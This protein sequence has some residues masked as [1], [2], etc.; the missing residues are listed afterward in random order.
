MK[1][2]RWPTQARSW[3]EWGS[4]V[5]RFG[6][7]EMNMLRYDYVPVNVSLKLRRTRSKSDSKSRRLASV[8]NNRSLP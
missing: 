6:E 4:S 5:L 8:V 1:D 2:D 7:Q 3:L